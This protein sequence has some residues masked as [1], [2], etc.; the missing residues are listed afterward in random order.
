MEPEEANGK[1]T[2]CK[3]DKPLADEEKAEEQ[4]EPMPSQASQP[5]PVTWESLGEQKKLFN[6]DILPKVNIC[7]YSSS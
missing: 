2:S 5:A 4:K 1:N 6:F 7:P 3:D